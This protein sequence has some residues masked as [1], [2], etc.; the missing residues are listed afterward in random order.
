MK[1]PFFT[2][3]LFAL[4]GTGIM[5]QEGVKLGFSGLFPLDDFNDEVTLGLAVDA[6]YMHALGE[7]VDLGVMTGFI[8]GFP[9]TFDNDINL[10]NLPHVQF[11]PVAASVRVWPNNNFSFGGDVGY[12][13]GINSGNSG[14]LYYRPVVG[15]LLG[16]QSEINLSY[17]TV[18]L[19]TRTWNTIN[20]GFL[21]TLVF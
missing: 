2:L 3:L 1:K 7:V 20:L 14:G 16:A 11:L 17:T 12:G 13:I 4:V 19:D 15:Y 10:D 9:E 6:G 18:E 21:F 5:A 8:N